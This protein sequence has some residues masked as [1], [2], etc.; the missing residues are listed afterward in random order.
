MRIVI[1]IEGDRVTS[2]TV[3]GATPAGEPPAELLRRAEEQGA[4]SAGPAPE[5]EKKPARRPAARARPARR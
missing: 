2:A 1:E 5:P 3:E 4:L